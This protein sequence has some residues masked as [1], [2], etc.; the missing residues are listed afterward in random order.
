MPL[1]APQLVAGDVVIEL[2]WSL[3]GTRASPGGEV[4]LAVHVGVWG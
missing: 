1:I 4:I 2:G 3:L